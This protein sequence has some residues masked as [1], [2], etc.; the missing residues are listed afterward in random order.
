MKQ[1]MDQPLD[2]RLAGVDLPGLGDVL[3]DSLFT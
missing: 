2:W 1:G 3:R